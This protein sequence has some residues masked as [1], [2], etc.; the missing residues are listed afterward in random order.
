MKSTYGKVAVK[1]SDGLTDIFTDASYIVEDGLLYVFTQKGDET[2]GFPLAHVVA[3]GKWV[4]EGSED[5]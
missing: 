1:T 4:T 2:Y 5:A 3:F